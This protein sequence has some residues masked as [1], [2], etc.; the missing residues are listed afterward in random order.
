MQFY[1]EYLYLFSS[2]PNIEVKKKID[3]LNTGIPI[4]SSTN[5]SSPTFKTLKE[6]PQ[7]SDL[8]LFPYPTNKTPAIHSQAK[9]S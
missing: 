3:K 9:Y 6:L 4:L 1:V 5:S 8:L 7:D 2:S